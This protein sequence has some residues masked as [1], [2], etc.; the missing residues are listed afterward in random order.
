MGNA[1]LTSA[2]F[3]SRGEK[4]APLPGQQRQT[5]ERDFH[6][7]LGRE[8]GSPASP[9]S[10]RRLPGARTAAARRGGESRSRSPGTGRAVQHLRALFRRS[11]L[12]AGTRRTAPAAGALLRD[13]LGAT[14]SA[15][16]IIIII[17]III[18]IAMILLSLPATFFSLVG[19][20]LGVCPSVRPSAPGAAPRPAL[21]ISPAAPQRCGCQAVRGTLPT[22]AGRGA[23]EKKDGSGSRPQGSPSSP[24]SSAPRRP[25]PRRAPAAAPAEGGPGR[26][27]G[28]PAVPAGWT[29][30]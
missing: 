5:P 25:R 14:G 28:R 18:V 22:P 20:E 24:P 8:R 13:V 4:S 27:G 6:F 7:A 16:N 29:L 15:V 19:P 1:C 26:R 12:R 10:P 21:R 17:T 23:G 9:A 30:H 11:C 3:P 2:G